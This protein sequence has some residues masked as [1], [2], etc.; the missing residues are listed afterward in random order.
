MGAVAEFVPKG[1]VVKTTEQFPD[2]DDLDDD[3]PKK[4]KK[5]EKKKPAPAK[6]EEEVIDESTAWKGKPSKFFT[7]EIDEE[8]Q[9]TPENPGNFKMNQEQWNFIYKYYPEYGASPYDL[10][11]WLFNQAVQEEQ[12]QSMMYGAGGP[13]GGRRPGEDEKEEDFDSI[14][15]K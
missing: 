6:V 14:M 10:M 5:K 15:N 12:R 1:A 4:K 3:Q 8:N 13:L 11:V 7:L 9:P 2:L